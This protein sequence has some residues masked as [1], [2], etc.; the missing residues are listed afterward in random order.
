MKFKKFELKNILHKLKVVLSYLTIAFIA[1]EIRGFMLY[2]PIIPY[3]W[4]LKLTE[5]MVSNTKLN[6]PM[7]P[8]QKCEDFNTVVRIM[9]KSFPSHSYGH[10][11]FY[12]FNPEDPSA[13]VEPVIE[14]G[15]AYDEAGIIKW[16]FKDNEPYIAF[17]L[18][19]NWT[20][21]YDNTN[22]K[23]ISVQQISDSISG[24]K[25]QMESNGFV[26]SEPNNIPLYRYPQG[27][28]ARKIGFSKNNYLYHFTVIEEDPPYDPALPREDLPFDFQKPI[29]I[30]MNC[31]ENSLELRSMYEQ[32]LSIPHQFT[33]ETSVVYGGK[34][35]NL[36]RFSLYYPGGVIDQWSDELYDVRQ[37]PMQLVD[38]KNNFFLCSTF[39]KI[40]IGK[41]LPC[42]RPE[43]REFDVVSY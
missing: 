42:Y 8:P 28:F 14:R 1:F 24:F 9:G 13:Q 35:D 20:N 43:K 39:E 27:S 15:V 23:G 30:S 2:D 22:G 6:N 37:N 21:Y 36:A 18:A 32:Y 5:F 11:G 29:R 10:S 31:A 19:G 26:F 7:V 16:R 17:E 33:N 34:K 3:T 12:G 38:N 40:K 4:P 41:K 25:K